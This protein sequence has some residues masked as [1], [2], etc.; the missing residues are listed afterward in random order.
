MEKIFFELHI[1]DGYP[2]VKEESIWGIRLEN[3][4]F[5][6]NNIPFYT[7]EVSFEDIVSVSNNKGILHYKKTMKSSGNSTIRV[8]FFDKE[9]V[10]NCINSIKKM[11]CECEKFSSTFIA[12]NIPITTNIEI[13]LDYLEYLSSKEIADYEYGKIS[14]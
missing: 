5:K 3:N 6:I 11:G 1:E 13:I 4:L 8:I 9:N 7:K 10:E 12:I 2:P 14:Q